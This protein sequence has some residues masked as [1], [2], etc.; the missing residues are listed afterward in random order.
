MNQAKQAEHWKAQGRTVEVAGHSIFV[1]ESNNQDSDLPYLLIL[2]GYP[3]CS[4]DYHKVLPLLSQYFRV[5][6]HD[7][8]GFGFSDKPADYSYTL[9]D[10][11]DVALMLWQKLGIN[12]AHVLA[13]DYGTS[14]ATELV[15]RDNHGLFTDF[16]IETLTLCNGSMHIE[17]A[18]LRLIQRLLLNR[19]TGP[20]VAQLSNRNTLAKNLRQIYVDG[21]QVTDEE[22]DALWQMMTHNDGKSVIHQTTQY[23]KQRK[24]FWHRWIGALQQTQ[25]PVHVLWAEND[26][27]AVIEMAQ[28]LYDEIPNAALTTLPKLGHFPMAESPDRW[29]QAVVDYLL[30]A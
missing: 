1:I 25:L 9:V 2:H 26:R 6:V 10:Q 11:C 29:G 28:V 12:E 3:T 24:Q 7:H 13:H 5:V 17:L 22:V 8:L 4:F 18:Q 27:L 15:A 30:K 14:V 23:I 20:K 19:F 16:S 21:T